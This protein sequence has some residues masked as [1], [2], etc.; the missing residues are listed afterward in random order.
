MPTPWLDRGKGDQ[1]QKVNDF[2]L[3]L[4]NKKETHFEPAL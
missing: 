1:D 2:L 4:Q 3:Q